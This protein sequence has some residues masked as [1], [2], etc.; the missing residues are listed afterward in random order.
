MVTLKKPIHG[1]ETLPLDDGHGSHAFGV[2]T[3]DVPMK[4][5]SWKPLENSLKTLDWM[6][7]FD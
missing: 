5:M 6:L 3:I 1:V 7:S 4:K 2:D